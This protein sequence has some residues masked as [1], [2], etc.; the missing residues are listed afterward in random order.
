MS[1]AT[2][3]VLQIHAEFTITCCCVTHRSVAQMLELNPLANP[4]PQALAKNKA[5][6]KVLLERARPKGTYDAVSE[7]CKP[8]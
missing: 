2:P 8:S 6:N 5:I 7:C 4:T 3:S 1:V